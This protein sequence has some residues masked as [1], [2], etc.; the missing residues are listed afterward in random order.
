VIPI[1]D[2]IPSSRI[3]A[4][5]WALLAANVGAFVFQVTRPT[6]TAFVAFVYDWALVPTRINPFDGGAGEALAA[7]PTL[8]TSIF[9]HGD[10]AHL[11]GNMLFL[12]IFGD[13]VEDRL[14]HL[15][16]ILFYLAC[17]LVASAVQLVSNPESSV[18]ILGASGAIG[19]VM[20]AYMIAYPRARVLM[21][22]WIFIFV[23]LIW[24]PAIFFLGLWFLI[25]ILSAA[26]TP[27]GENGGVAF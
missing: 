23:R 2:D 11:I 5:N 20:G 24:V 17:G 7:T 21:F 9:L 13:N 8:L 10:A 27:P 26:A 14:G 22:F 25:Q 19:G 12:W 18:P 16:Y 3:P 4:V 6:E 1:R 15:K